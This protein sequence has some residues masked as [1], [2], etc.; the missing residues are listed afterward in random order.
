MPQ[1]RRSD[2][3]LRLPT[4]GKYHLPSW[5]RHPKG[6]GA[7]HPPNAGNSLALGQGQSTI[8]DSRRAQWKQWRQH[9]GD[10]YD[11]FICWDWL[12]TY[13]RQQEGAGFIYKGRFTGDFYFPQR[14]LAWLIRGQT[15]RPTP[16]VA[17]T[18]AQFQKRGIKAVQLLSNDIQQH[19]LY[20][21]NQAYQGRQLGGA[22]GRS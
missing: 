3:A 18:L 13:A 5:F 2:P 21:L 8:E 7:P 1:S 11:L 14:K 16:S 20:T 15:F 10:S 6:P 4:L 22:A 19:T 9:P 17:Y 12:T